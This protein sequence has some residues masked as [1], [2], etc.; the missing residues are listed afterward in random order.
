MAFYKCY[1][2]ECTPNDDH[3]PECPNSNATNDAA[4]FVKCYLGECEYDDNH[5]SNCEKAHTP[6]VDLDYA[7]NGRVDYIKH[8]HL[9]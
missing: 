2:G 4:V 5:A 8:L 6:N 3:D 1:N 7:E 9:K